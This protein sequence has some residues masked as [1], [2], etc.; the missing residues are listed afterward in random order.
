MESVK[1][2]E[3]LRL[4]GDW[5]K[6]STKHLRAPERRSDLLCY[7]TGENVWGVQTNQKALATYA[8][9]AT[10]EGKH[11]I[12]QDEALD[13]ALKLL[14]FSLESH[15]EGS[16]HCADGDRWGHTW[17]SVLGLERAA[18]A[19]EALEPHL[20]DADKALLEKVL[21]SEALWLLDSYPVHSGLISNNKPESNL[22][23]GA[24]LWRVAALYPGTPKAAD[25]VE[26]GNLFLMNSI[27]VPADALSELLVEGRPAKAWQQAPNF[28]DSFSLNHHGYLNVGYM[29]ICLSQ[30]A[31][32]HFSFKRQ[33]LKAPDSLYW[34]AADLWRL[35][36]DFTFPDGRLCRIGGDTRVRYCYCQDYCVPTWLFAMDYLG[37]RD[38]VQFERRWLEI[39]ETETLA[40]GDGSFLSSRLVEMATTSPLYYTRLESDRAATLSMAA[41][42]KSRFKELE[43]DGPI[44]TVVDRDIQWSDEHHGAAFI[45]S[46]RRIASWVWEASE[47]PQGLCLPPTR[48]DLA[49][50]RQNLAGECHGT[51][52]V[53]IN[54]P[55][56]RHVA[57]FPGGFLTYGAFECVNSGELAEGVGVQDK[58]VATVDVAF[59]ALPED[60]TVLCVQWAKAPVSVCLSSVKSLKLNVP[61]DLF[62]GKRRRYVTAS[63]EIVVQGAGAQAE[64]LDLKSSWAKIDDALSVVVL[65]P[66]GNLLLR[67]P[68]R[69]NVIIKDKPFGGGNLHADE[70]CGEV[71]R[72]PLFLEPGDTI[73]ETAFAIS[74]GDVVP[75]GGA[76]SAPSL[77]CRTA[78]IQG[79]DGQSYLLAANFGEE[80]AELS[81]P[82]AAVDLVS[83]E[84]L[85]IL[86]ALRLDGFSAKLLKLKIQ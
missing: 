26:K 51:G 82:S 77:S 16:F 37:D 17:I 53:N 62:N 70:L 74:C 43:P 24:F 57:N 81:L 49:E 67:R 54:R 31:M 6:H 20:A 61:N 58:I 21:V 3:Y 64:T 2:S 30:V 48:S 36:K 19:F 56:R 50:W 39:V 80:P 69:R 68:G 9:L 13:T 55:L 11:G 38:C 1:T 33:G 23:N 32:L 8:V 40:N 76:Y 65:G 29:V 44:P 42:W 71:R 66:G 28:F 83:G 27:N 22:W 46:Q 85:D 4:I 34:H 63:G 84:T 14:R 10:E 7:G 86:A 75:G 45:R 73:F 41:C 79:L 25:F 18:H 60:A 12:G 72:G 15:L 5:A 59:A 78:Q 47:K 52:Q 35:V